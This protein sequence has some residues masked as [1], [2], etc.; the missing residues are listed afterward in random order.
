[1]TYRQFPSQLIPN[2]NVMYL[3]QPSFSFTSAFTGVNQNVSMP[4]A[5][6]TLEMNFT[7]L[8]GQ[9]K[10]ILSA[11]IN[12]LGGR[13]E[14]VKVFDH[15]RE[16]KPAMGAP[17][18]SGDDQLGRKLLTSGWIPNKKVLEI[19]D[20]F[21]VNDELKEVEQ[22]CWA[23]MNGFATIDFNPPLRKS[24]PNSA[25]L[26]T[27]KPYMLATLDGDGVKLTNSPAGFGQFETVVFME[28]I[29]K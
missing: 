27:E 10:R 4:A 16:G 3:S 6:W 29:Y 23:D 8:V 15:A 13:V 2:E 7:P 19:G 22:D 17:A 14:A 5:R 18:V 26:E 9:K 24:P 1:M 21:T 28:A 20:L 12:S 11:F 25:A